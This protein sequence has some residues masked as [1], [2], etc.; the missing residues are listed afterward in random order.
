MERKRRRVKRIGDVARESGVG[1]ETI[2][3]YEREGL[4]EQPQRPERG[5]REYGERQ[6]MQL[7]YVRLGQELGLTLKDVRRLQTVARGPQESFCGTVRETIEARVGRLDAEIAE[8]MRR[9][10]ALSQWLR[11]CEARGAQRDCPLYRQLQPV[12]GKARRK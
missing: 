6:V 3:F 2:R 11:Q 4:I 9:R 1:V 12:I 7:S 8:L 10:N 5:W